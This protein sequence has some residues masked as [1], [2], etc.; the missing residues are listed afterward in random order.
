MKRILI[1]I[2]VIL[3]FGCFT[4]FAGYNVGEC[5]AN[6]VDF[7]ISLNGKKVEF[8]MPVVTIDDRTYLPLREICNTLGVSINW[9]EEE[10]KIEMFTNNN[11]QDDDGSE[12]V[13]SGFNLKDFKFIKLGMSM[14]EIHKM[15]GEPSYYTGSGILWG[16]YKLNDGNKLHLNDHMTGYLKAVFLETSDGVKIPLQFDEN[17]TLEI[18]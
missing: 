11:V 4:A 17:G 1:T 10:S 12:A 13:E 7:D 14:D 16:V 8:S 9:V 18:S 15:V 2:M 3:S 6:I 5:N